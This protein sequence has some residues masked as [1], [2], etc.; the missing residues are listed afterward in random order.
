MSA[1][2]TSVE[3]PVSLRTPFRA[4]EILF[5]I[6]NRSEDEFKPFSPGDTVVFRVAVEDLD[7]T[8]DLDDLEELL[9]L[10]FDPSKSQLSTEP[11][12]S[13]LIVPSSPENRKTFMISR[14]PKS[15][16]KI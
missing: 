14:R 4:I 8:E 12:F 5:L 16:T 3:H 6:R 13:V 9:A 11:K 7:L 10:D 2:S 1:S 15:I